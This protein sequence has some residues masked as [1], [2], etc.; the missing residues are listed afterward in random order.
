MTVFA[1]WRTDEADANHTG[2]ASTFFSTV[3]KNYPTLPPTLL[4]P[5]L[6]LCLSIFLFGLIAA[7]NSGGR[8]GRVTA[9]VQPNPS[10]H[11]PIGANYFYTDTPPRPT[12]RPRLLLLLLLSLVFPHLHYSL[13]LS[14]TFPRLPSPYH[15]RQ[16]ASTD[17]STSRRHLLFS[18]AF[19]AATAAADIASLPPPPPPPP[20]P[21][22]PPPPPPAPA[23]VPSF[24][25][26]GPH[27]PPG[28]AAA[29]G[30]RF[31]SAEETVPEFPLPA[32][33]FVFAFEGPLRRAF[34]VALPLLG[35]KGRAGGRNVR[36]TGG[37]G[38]EK[39]KRRGI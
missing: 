25:T 36:A 20:V 30:P 28:P 3:P 31:R 21:P 5:F 7:S 16:P 39:G 27:P 26:P 12:P 15:P 10:L 18:S 33:T 35:C 19:A 34:A 9:Q 37:K 13:H 32:S 23:P 29:R 14:E 22:P 8:L 2:S 4:F 11:R 1:S 17:P 24:L 6:S 38:K